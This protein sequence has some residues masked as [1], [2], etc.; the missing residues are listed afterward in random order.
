M[1]TLKHILAL[2]LCVTLLFGVCGCSM[3]KSGTNGDA[4]A[5]GDSMTPMIGSSGWSEDSDG[6][7]TP[8]SD[9]SSGES[10][11]M[12]DTDGSAD[13][14][15]PK[16]EVEE[17][18]SSAGLITAGAWDDNKYY[19]EWTKLF[20]Q[21]SGEDAAGKFA[22][23][24]GTKSWNFDCF[25]RIK[26]TVGLESDENARVAGAKVVAKDAGGESIFEAVTDANGV[27]Y[28]F[29][30]REVYTLTVTSGDHTALANYTG[31][32]D[33]DVSVKLSGGA[34]KKNIIDIMFVVDVTGSMGD[35]L[36]FLKRE[37]ADL[38]DRVASG[39]A[40]T[41]INLA[42]LFYRD[43]S[44]A[45]KFTYKDFTD[46]TSPEGLAAVQAALDSEYADGGGDYPEAVDE[47]LELAIGKQWNTAATTKLIFH[48]LDAPPHSKT[49]NMERY[50]SAVDAAAA[51]GIRICPILCSGAE[52]LTEYL[53]RQ[54]AIRTGGT[55]I[56]VTDDSGI[57][58]SHHDPNLPNVTVEL[59]N[60]LLVRLISGYHSGEF[61]PPVYW[62]T[63]QADN[64]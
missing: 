36:D 35:E 7:F 33:A 37:L 44:D 13:D 32:L 57:G 25:G 10:D 3:L 30:D 12:S 63:D 16:E 9:I 59:L 6:G 60:S 61:A 34:E 19:E 24:T 48:V 39:S 14:D 8:D 15:T 58:N 51:K 26:V 54:A 20:E 27:A 11:V 29:V 45:K 41:S 49:E 56:Y 52:N 21:A 2:A 40:D 4:A 64:K 62:K 55:F 53:V 22:S 1:K 42:L 46:V 31:L 43:D 17:P 28:L 23:Y 18:G 5:P 47:A 50:K 38:I